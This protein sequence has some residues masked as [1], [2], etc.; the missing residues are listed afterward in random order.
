MDYM[1]LTELNK[2]TTAVSFIVAET[3]EK[4]EKEHRSKWQLV[5]DDACHHFDHDLR[6]LVL[7]YGYDFDSEFKIFSLD[8]EWHMSNSVSMARIFLNIGPSKII[9][10]KPMD[11]GDTILSNEKKI[12]FQSSNRAFILFKELKKI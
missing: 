6:K 3:L 10:P 12:Y 2:Y 8:T 5:I 1:Y 7:S 9:L 11:F 4:L